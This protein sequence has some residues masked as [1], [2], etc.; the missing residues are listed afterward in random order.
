MKGRRRGSAGFKEGRAEDLGEGAGMEGPRR[1]RPDSV[2][3]RGT[4]E[5][6]EDRWDPLVSGGAIARRSAGASGVRCGLSAG[7]KGELGRRVG[8]GLSSGWAGERE[9]MGPQERGVGLGLG[10]AL[11]W[12]LVL[13]FLSISPFLFLIQTNTQLGEFKFK[14]EFTTSTQTKKLM[15]QH[16]CNTNN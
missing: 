8:L 1:S 4:R 16:E 6:G 10:F 2:A 14:F 11:G 3:R 5:E 7:R 12:F 13:G 9:E 15:H